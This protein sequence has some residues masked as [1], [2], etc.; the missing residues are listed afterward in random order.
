MCV[1]VCVC[2]CGVQVT[3]SMCV[4]TS[5]QIEG[6]FEDINFSTK[7]TRDTLEEICPDLF[8]CV[9]NPVQDVLKTTEITMVR[10]HPALAGACGSATYFEHS[11][12]GDYKPLLTGGS[13]FGGK[14]EVATYHSGIATSLTVCTF[15]A[16]THTFML[17]LHIIF[18]ILVRRH[19]SAAWCMHMWSQ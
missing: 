18:M 1:C 2:V 16:P 19:V 13:H 8:E 5:S 9:K 6:L 15:H 10:P 11:N 14:R 12:I 17:S 3:L 4:P 7:V